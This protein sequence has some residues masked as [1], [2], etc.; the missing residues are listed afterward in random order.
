VSD[1]AKAFGAADQRGI[2]AHREAL[3]AKDIIWSPRRGFL[4]FTVPLFDVFL[5]DRVGG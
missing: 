2:S 4:D 1:V 3:I 5:R